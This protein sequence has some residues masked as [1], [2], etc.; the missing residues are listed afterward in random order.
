MWLVDTSV[1]VD[2]F[3]RPSRV[4]LEQE[5]TL[6]AVVTC[7]PIVQEVLQGFGDERAHNIARHSMLAF[8]IL[9]DVMP[10]QRWVEAAQLYRSAR[11]AGVTVRSSMDCLIAAIALHHQVGVLHCDRDFDALARVCP[12]VARNLRQ[13]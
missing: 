2:V 6:D 12:L 1:W 10:T 9:D 13:P 8:P 3:A 5:V 11:R 4:S 7:P